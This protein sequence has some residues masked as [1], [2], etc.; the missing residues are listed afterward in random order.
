[1]SE[2]KKGFAGFNIGELLMGMI[3]DKAMVKTVGGMLA[4]ALDKMAPKM[5]D[6]DCLFCCPSGDK[7]KLRMLKGKYTMN[8]VDRTISITITGVFDIT[9]IVNGIDPSKL[10]KDQQEKITSELT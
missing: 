7:T 1:M 6:H 2:K 5:A 10:T 4:G 3:S 9:E 8:P